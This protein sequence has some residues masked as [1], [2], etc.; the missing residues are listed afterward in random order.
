[1]Q[2]SAADMSDF[3]GLRLLKLRPGRMHEISGPVPPPIGA[4]DAARPAD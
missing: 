3:D 1:M 2:K 4:E